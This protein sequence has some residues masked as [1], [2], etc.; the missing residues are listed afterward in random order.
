MGEK[1]LA[2]K[3]AEGCASSVVRACKPTSCKHSVSIS[4]R[5][6]AGCCPGPFS[7]TVS[8]SPRHRVLSR[9]CEQ[10]PQPS[11]KT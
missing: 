7:A 3:D 4:P 8:L 6:E 1:T 5:A 9:L 2:S 10:R 11:A